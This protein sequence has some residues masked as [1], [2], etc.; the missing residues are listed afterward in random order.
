MNN[1]KQKAIIKNC[2]D[3]QLFK[4]LESNFECIKENIFCAVRTEENI[5][6]L[7]LIILD[8]FRNRN[9]FVSKVV[10]NKWQRITHFNFTYTER[11]IQVYDYINGK[12]IFTQIGTY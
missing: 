7:I 5:K 3:E 6:K 10:F 8:E 1:E 12:M 9:I 2:T 11:L 4:N